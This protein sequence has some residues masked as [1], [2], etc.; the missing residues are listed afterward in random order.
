MFYLLLFVPVIYPISLTLAVV[1]VQVETQSGMSICLK[2]VLVRDLRK[3]PSYEV[4]KGK[5]G[6]KH[7]NFPL[8]LQLLLRW[9]SGAEIAL[10]SYPQW[11][12]K[13]WSLYSH[14]SQ[15]LAVGSQKERPLP[16]VRQSSVARVTPRGVQV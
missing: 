5:I 10:L 11:K 12:Q 4:G 3:Y 14:I 9:Y 13:A 15:P 8:R 16:W 7:N 1:L 2:K 6:Q